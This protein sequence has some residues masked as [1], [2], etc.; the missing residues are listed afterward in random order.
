V[1]GLV[2]P[3]KA[4]ASFRHVLGLLGRGDRAMHRLNH[5]TRTHQWRQ[6]Y[7]FVHSAWWRHLFKE[8]GPHVKL[9]DIHC[10]RTKHTS[11]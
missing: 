10:S 6:A 1:A 2:P 9:R 4:A 8:F 11:A 5:L 7:L 3:P